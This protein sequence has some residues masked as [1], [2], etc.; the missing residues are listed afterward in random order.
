VSV[1]EDQRL[2][3]SGSLTPKGHLA[4]GDL[5]IVDERGV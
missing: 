2:W 5:G 4:T 1:D 3:I